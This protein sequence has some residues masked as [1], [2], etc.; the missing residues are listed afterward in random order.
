MSSFQQLPRQAMYRSPAREELPCLTSPMY[1]TSRD[2]K[3]LWSLSELPFC[4]SLARVDRHR[5]D[6][7][8]PKDRQSELSHTPDQM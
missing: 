3:R 8:D 1:P 7:G 6:C 4:E 5:L 2:K